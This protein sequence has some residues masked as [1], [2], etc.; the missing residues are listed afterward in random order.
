MGLRNKGKKLGTLICMATLE[1]NSQ[2]A[3]LVYNGCGDDDSPV[4]APSNEGL[5]R[6]QRHAA[7]IQKWSYSL[8][9][10]M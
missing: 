8:I 10:V 4:Q 3:L 5:T 7:G 9:F 2:N 6:Y 1:G